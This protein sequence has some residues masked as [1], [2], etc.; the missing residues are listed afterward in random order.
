MIQRVPCVLLRL[1]SFA[2][3]SELRAARLILADVDVRVR[4]PTL[5]CARALRRLERTRGIQGTDGLDSGRTFQLLFFRSRFD[6]FVGEN[7]TVLGID[8]RS[9]F[10]DVFGV[11]FHMI[12]DRFE[13]SMVS[14]VVRKERS[15]FDPVILPRVRCHIECGRQFFMLQLFQPLN[16]LLVLSP[17]MID[18]LPAK[19]T[20]SQRK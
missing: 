4:N 6:F 11:Q 16:R 12:D 3:T 17:Q 19:R 18:R 5:A 10:I 15:V 1:V 2:R 13:G 7:G 14:K 20:G 9:E 8:L